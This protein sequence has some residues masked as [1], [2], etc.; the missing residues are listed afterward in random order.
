MTP[1]GNRQAVILAG[2][3]GSRLAP[4][5]TVLPKPLM[6]LGEFSIL[7]IVLRQ[8]DQQGF[9][10][11]VIATGYLS[12]IIEAFCHSLRSK[13]GLEIRIHR[14]EEPQGTIGPLRQIEGLRDDFLLMNGDLLT[15]LPFLEVL[16]RRKV[17]RTL[18]SVAVGE[19]EHTID[20]GVL[21]LDSEGSVCLYREKPK[22][23][24]WVSLGVYALSKEVLAWIPQEGRFDFPDLIQ[25]LLDGNRK[26]STYPFAGYWRDIGRPEDYEAAK[27][28]F[29]SNPERFLP[30]S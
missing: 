2:G 18:V 5:N 21:K 8:L 23:K 20:F 4:F 30:G 25:L 13:L 1:S 7:E 19:R 16:E 29:Q 9:Q 12:E 24:D 11:A 10:E 15:V 28:D 14:E 27:I 22:M 3:R 26:I 17:E 6:P